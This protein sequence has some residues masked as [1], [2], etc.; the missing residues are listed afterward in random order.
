MTEVFAWP[1]AAPAAAGIAAELERL[2]ATVF[3]PLVALA[4]AA[5]AAI[6]ADRAPLLADL[7]VVRPAAVAQLNRGDALVAGCGLIADPGLIADAP[8]HLA[9]WTAGAD[10]EIA[11][12]RVV[13]DPARDGFRDYTVLEWWSVP[14]RTGR[15]H[16]TGPYVDY[17]CTDAYTLTFTVPVR[18]ADG[19]MAA[20]V[21]SDVYV[22][23]AERLLLPAL[24]ACGRPATVVN[25][26]GRVVVSTLPEH[27]TGSL[28]RSFPA[29]WVRHD[30][31]DVP[32]GVLVCG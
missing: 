20:V 2:C 15:R 14:R 32:F 4:E 25:R 28:V 8:W 23:R 16:I 10:R 3:A 26:A 21:G 13:S 22:A 24:R 29:G 9:W 1:A 18:R 5:A 30:C 6:P 31:G 7:G 17:L 11:P 27:V 12:L 19:S